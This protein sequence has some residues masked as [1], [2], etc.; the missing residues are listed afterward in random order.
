MML[1]KIVAIKEVIDHLKEYD[2]STIEEIG[3]SEYWY[4]GNYD[5]CY[6]Y[7]L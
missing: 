3:T 7:G 2:I 1:Q 4:S 5:D 6:E